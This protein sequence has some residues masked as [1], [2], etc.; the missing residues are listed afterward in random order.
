MIWKGRRGSDNIVDQRRMGAGS[1]GVGGLVIGAVIYFLMGGNPLVYLAQ[2]AG[3][4]QA[5]TSGATQEVDDANDEQK[6]F[7]SVVLAD[8]EDVWNAQFEQH[9]ASYRPPKLVLF[10]RGVR[11]AC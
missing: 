11:T 8:T 6:Q 4:L 1:M 9:S 5:P 2:N 7:V 3:E 10:R